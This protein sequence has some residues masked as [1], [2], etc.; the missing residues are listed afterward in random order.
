MHSQSVQQ[1]TARQK[2]LAVKSMGTDTE[3]DEKIGEWDWRDGPAVK[4]RGPKFSPKQPP[5][6]AHSHL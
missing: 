4:S 2:L 6:T 5:Q 3:P 1:N